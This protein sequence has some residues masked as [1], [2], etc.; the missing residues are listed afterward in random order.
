MVLERKRDGNFEKNKKGDDLSD[1]CVCEAIDRRNS[2]ESIDMSGI[3]ESL[4]RMAK[5][6]SMRW[7]GHVLRKKEKM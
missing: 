6:S 2:E 7:N 3:K 1:V 5:A 4:N